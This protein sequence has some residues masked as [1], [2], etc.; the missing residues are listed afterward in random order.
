[1]QDN[2]VVAVEGV[3]MYEMYVRV[4]MCYEPDIVYALVPTSDKILTTTSNVAGKTPLL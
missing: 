2:V 4:V 1:M 3:K